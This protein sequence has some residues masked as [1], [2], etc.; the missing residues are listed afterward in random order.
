MSINREVLFMICRDN[1]VLY[2]ATCFALRFKE[3]L[4]YLDLLYSSIAAQRQI[5]CYRN[6]F[7]T[8]RTKDSVTLARLAIL[9][10]ENPP[11]ESR[12]STTS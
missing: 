9:E 4:L 7:F 3:N 2:L 6:L 1:K 10:I 8:L 11:A 5:L 12:F